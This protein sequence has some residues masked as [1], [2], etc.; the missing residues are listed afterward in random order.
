M[1]AGSV[2]GIA[3]RGRGCA[4]LPATGRVLGKVKVTLQNYRES[5]D[6]GKIVAAVGR[7][8]ARQRFVSP[9]EVFV[10]L[11]L[12][13]PD[14]LQ[15]WKR[16]QVP[17]L[18]RVIHC[19][20]SRAG[21]ILRVLRFHAHD[22]NLKPSHTC[23]HH[24]KHPLRFSKSGEPL[25][26]EAYARHFVVVGKRNPFAKEEVPCPDSSDSES[27]QA[28]LPLELGHALLPDGEGRLPGTEADLG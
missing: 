5:K 9:V 4:R 2:F 25:I 6:Y 23:Y 26:E 14:D 3:G 19:N 17:Y 24:R 7:I 13:M 8:L 10:E 20:L 15:K 16:G 22:L 27:Q 28:D 11:Q 1:I 21:R 18:E 12:L